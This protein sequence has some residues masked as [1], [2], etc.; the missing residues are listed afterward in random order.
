MISGGS[1]AY[2]AALTAAA[3]TGLVALALRQRHVALTALACGVA[4]F[5]VD[6]YL[7]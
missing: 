1:I 6:V 3:A 7:Y 5:L 4:A 2:A